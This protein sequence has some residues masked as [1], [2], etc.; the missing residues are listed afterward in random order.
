MD[1]TSWDQR[2][3]RYTAKFG[4]GRKY[5]PSLFSGFD[6]P[7]IDQIA[8][9]VFAGRLRLP[10]LGGGKVLLIQDFMNE[11]RSDSEWGLGQGLDLLETRGWADV[12]SGVVET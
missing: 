11:I 2:E 3:K 4:A 10:T 8:L 1:A 12:A 7:E 5:I 9:L 6:L